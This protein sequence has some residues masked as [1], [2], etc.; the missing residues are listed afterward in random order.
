ML[1]VIAIVDA[2]NSVQLDESLSL[3]KSQGR[4]SISSS[5]RLWKLMCCH[6][7]VHESF[8]SLL[9]RRFVSCNLHRQC[10]S[11]DI[12]RFTF[13]ALFVGATN[14][15]MTR[16]SLFPTMFPADWVIADILC[17]SWRLLWQGIICGDLLEL[18]K[19]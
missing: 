7:S 13:L 12:F 11:S 15:I 8:V 6:S 14:R 4:R 1:Y 9:C 18:P 10:C 16:P 17:G 19:N 2:A 3:K 5:F